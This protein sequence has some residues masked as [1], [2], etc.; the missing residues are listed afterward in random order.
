[1]N[2]RMIITCIGGFNVN[3]TFKYLDYDLI[4]ANPNIPIIFGIDFGHVFP[5]ITY[6]IGGKV[7]IKAKI[8]RI[9]IQIIEH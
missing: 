3:Q 8:D 2:V 5:I 1:M 4:G 7:Q 6:P 9:D